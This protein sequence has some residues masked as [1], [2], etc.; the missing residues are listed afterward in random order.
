MEGRS[1]E[2]GEVKQKR[3]L[4]GAESES[5]RSKD[6]DDRA[7][8]EVGTMG[9]AITVASQDLDERGSSGASRVLQGKVLRKVRGLGGG[10]GRG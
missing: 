6:G 8:R 4:E 7:A 3:V 2:G 5:W 9:R 10:S 1:E